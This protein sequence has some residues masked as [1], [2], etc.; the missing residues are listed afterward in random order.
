M[1]RKN[2]QILF[3]IFLLVFAVS[4]GQQAS[5][6]TEITPEQLAKGV[7]VEAACGECMFEL[8][9]ESCDLAVKINGQAYF[10]DGAAID[11]HGD[12]HADDGMCTTV[13]KAEVAGEIKD[14][15]FISKS[16]NLLPLN[17]DGSSHAHD[18]SDDGHTHEH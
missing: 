14:G 2:T 13:R 6:T 5:K 4:C 18:H 10:V 3:G 11:A 15:R 9:G 8:P 16:F 12:A 17:D 7:V 1:K